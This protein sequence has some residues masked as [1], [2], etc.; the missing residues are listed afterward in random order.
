MTIL[1]TTTTTT[2]TEYIPTAAVI[3]PK[4]MERLCLPAVTI[5]TAIVTVAMIPLHGFAMSQVFSTVL[6]QFRKEI[7]V[8][9]VD[10]R[11]RRCV[12]ILTESAPEA[13]RLV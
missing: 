1:A 8:K 3:Y 11:R 7:L 9:K 6:T 2:T 13:V 4:D 10:R 12:P 5:A